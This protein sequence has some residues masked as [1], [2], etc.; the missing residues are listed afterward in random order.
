MK[1]HKYQDISFYIGENA[2]DN[3]DLFDKS[4]F[5]NNEYIWFHL[6]SFS[7]PH[8][9]MYSTIQELQNTNYIEFI[10]FGSR[11]CLDNSKYN[12]LKDCKIVYSPLKKLKKGEKVGEI[13]ISGKKKLWKVS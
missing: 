8:V 3:W 4:K 7:S 5:I 2:E 13:I 10:N 6:N 11:L 12:Y 1:L 9:I